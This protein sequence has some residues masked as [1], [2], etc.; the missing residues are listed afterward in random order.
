MSH[1]KSFLHIAT[2]PARI[3]IKIDWYKTETLL[4]LCESFINP[5]DCLL[6]YDNV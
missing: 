5:I 1:E 2:Q 3:S 4:E 6:N